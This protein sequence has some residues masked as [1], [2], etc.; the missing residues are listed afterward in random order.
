MLVSGWI[1]NTGRGLKCIWTFAGV[2]F[3]LKFP[4]FVLCLSLLIVTNR[5]CCY[6]RLARVGSGLP[7]CY[8]GALPFARQ[9]QLP[10]LDISWKDVLEWVW[11]RD[12]RFLW[13]F[14]FSA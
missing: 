12:L 5:Q 4:C 9:A 14:S 8:L 6:K 1:S 11:G 7:G 13:L 10:G 2:P 3:V